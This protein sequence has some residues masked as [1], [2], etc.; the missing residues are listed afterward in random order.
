LAQL[1]IKRLS[2]QKQEA[3]LEE[4]D[5]TQDSGFAEELTELIYRFVIQMPDA[6]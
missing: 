6:P 1:C 3:K 5:V 4:N 2:E